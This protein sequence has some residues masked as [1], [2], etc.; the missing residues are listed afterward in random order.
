MHPF[1]VYAV[2]QFYVYRV[3]QYPGP[4]IPFL[5]FKEEESDIFKISDVQIVDLVFLIATF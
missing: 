2:S 1:L 5:N 4:A 3:Q